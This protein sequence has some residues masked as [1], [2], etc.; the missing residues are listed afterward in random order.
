MLH[1][2]RVTAVAEGVSYLLLFALSMPLKYWAGIREPNLYIGYAHG[3][4]FLAY[5]VLAVVLWRERNW[6]LK[7]LFYLVLASL[8]PFGTFYVEKYWLSRLTPQA[9][10]SG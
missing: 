2:F 4:L 8:L 5:L 9:K 1:L 7:K 6:K 3:F 10:N